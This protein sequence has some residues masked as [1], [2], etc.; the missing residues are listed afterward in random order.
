MYS[1]STIDEAIIVCLLEDQQIGFLL[2]S[3][4][5]PEVDFLSLMFPV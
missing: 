2:I 5:C 1:A 3:I 4:I